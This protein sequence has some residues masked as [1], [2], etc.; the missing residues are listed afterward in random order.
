MIKSNTY[1]ELSPEELLR[2]IEEE[3]IERTPSKHLLIDF[4]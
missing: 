2:W 1:K 4:S 3:F